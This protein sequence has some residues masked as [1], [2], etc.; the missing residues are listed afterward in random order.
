MRQR[1]TNET[2]EVETGVVQR[3]RSVLLALDLTAISDRVLRRAT[4]LPL[5]RDAHLTIF[6]VVPGSLPVASRDRAVRDA[7][8][9]L[10]EEAAVLRKSLPKTVT[11]ETIVKVGDGTREIAKATR[12]AQAELIVMGRGGG[13][14]L[15]DL[16]IGSTAERVIRLMRVPVLVVR[17]PARSTYKKPALAVEFDEA[18]PHTLSVLRRLLSPAAV[19][20]TVIHAI[21]TPYH[22]LVYPS[23][24]R[25]EAEQF[26]SELELR[27]ASKM[28][29]LFVREIG[30]PLQLDAIRWKPHVR[31]G[32]ARMVIE[33]AVKRTGADLLVL[34]TA[35]RAGVAH[36]LLGTVAGDVLRAVSCDVLLVPPRASK[37]SHPARR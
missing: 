36:L 1:E 29:K 7:R 18:A 35:G 15:R 20:V 33:K 24:S 37:R 5:A 2:S 21:D 14:G 34:G 9:M 11:I 23:L 16:F 17:T 10:A 22:G 31:S 32:S 30:R 12:A 27:A 13:R 8:K 4:R 19:G 3:F 25:D 26:D 6:H 28:A